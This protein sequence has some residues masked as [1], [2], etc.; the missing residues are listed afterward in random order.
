LTG[1]WRNSPNDFCD[2]QPARRAD[3]F[4][5]GNW[6]CELGLRFPVVKLI[7]YRRDEVALEQS[8]NPLAAV[9]LARLKVL[10][11]K[12]TPATAGSG[13][14]DWPGGF[15]IDG[16]TAKQIRQLMRILRY[17]GPHLAKGD[18]A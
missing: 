10:E 9:I 15:T 1:N 8:P 13:S 4:G 14:D 2:E 11:T 3:R 7:D 6:D 18:Q 17:D 16:S 12:R 5:H